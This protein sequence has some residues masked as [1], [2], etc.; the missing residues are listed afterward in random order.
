MSL[1]QPAVFS[2]LTLETIDAYFKLF[3]KS[4]LSLSVQQTQENSISSSSSSHYPYLDTDFK[5]IE[6]IDPKMKFIL[7]PV[8]P[9]IR[10]GSTMIGHFTSCNL[11]YP[12]T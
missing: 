2:R 4:R 6:R 9:F 5:F 8:F 3:R 11:K 10:R 1:C 7:R 12:I